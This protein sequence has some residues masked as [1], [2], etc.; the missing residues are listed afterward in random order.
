MMEL[1]AD[2]GDGCD[3][4]EGGRSG[5]VVLVVARV[6]VMMGVMVLVEVVKVEGKGVW[7]NFID[8]CRYHCSFTS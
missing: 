3:G 6:V 8:V 7:L 4:R 5:V 1:L 2:C